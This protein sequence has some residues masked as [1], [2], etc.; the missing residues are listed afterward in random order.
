M[1]AREVDPAAPEV[2]DCLA[3]VFAEAPDP[4]RLSRAKAA[5]AV[6]EENG[7]ATGVA[8]VE[9]DPQKRADDCWHLWLFAVRPEARRRGVATLLLET[10]EKDARQA[11]IQTLRVRTYRRWADM[12]NMLD[13]RGW[14][15]MGA[16]PGDRHDGVAEDW[17]LVLRPEPLRTIVIG[18]NPEGRGGEWIEAIRSMPN[19]V[20]IVGICDTRAE[21]RAMWPDIAGDNDPAELI[22]RTRPDAAILALPHNAYEGPRNACMDAGVAILHEK[23]LACHLDEVLKLQAELTQTPVPIVVGVQRR[24]H[25]SYL[26]LK[27]CIASG[28]KPKSMVVRMVLGK[29]N[30]ADGWRA[31]REVAGGGALLD[32]GYHAVD[33]VHYLLDAPVEVIHCGLRY[34]NRPALAGEIET[35]AHLTGR[36]GAIWVKIVVDR[37]GEEKRESVTLCTDHGELCATRERVLRDGQMEY[38]CPGTWN[39]A[40]RGC[41]ARLALAR[42][43]ETTSIDLWDHLAALQVV[44]EAYASVAACGRG[45]A[46]ATGVAP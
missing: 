46:L 25:P 30:A 8:V 45:V 3:Q 16:E 42:G 24:A 20:Q 40:V 41:L 11:G 17:V 37:Q 22:K 10:I 21:V 38:E 1:I 7:S 26:Y 32:M 18:A 12:R 43:G 13:R 4:H 15:L 28:D 36:C 39:A 2:I 6:M 9:I 35:A 44:E 33:L 23:P 29:R 34:G 14:A 27:Q 5:W 19:L 31:A